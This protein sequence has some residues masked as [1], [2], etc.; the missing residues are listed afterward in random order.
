MDTAFSIPDYFVLA[1]GL[2]FTGSPSTRLINII[3]KNNLKEHFSKVKHILEHDPENKLNMPVKQTLNSV[4]GVYLCINLV[5]GSIY[6]G[7]ASINCLYRRYSGHLL[8]GKGGSLLVKNAVKKYGLENFAFVIIETTVE[9]KNKNIILQLEQKY[10]DML[11]PRYNILKKAGSLLNHRWSFESKLR[12]RNS[13]IHKNHLENLRKLSL[14]KLVS[15]E[16]RALL[17][18]KALNRG[19]VSLDTRKKMSISNNKSVKI[20]S[21]YAE[22]NL[23]HKNFNSIADAA[24]FFFNDRNRRSPLK[25]ALEKN[26]LILNKYYLRKEKK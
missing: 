23:L 15:L 5:N 11:N 25:Y 7:S 16:T 3:N 2:F 14:N 9:G 24:E 21:Y 20:V 26:T 10:I 4:A 12:L 1:S 17:K 13:E 19:P 22:S 8:N 6:V 18:E